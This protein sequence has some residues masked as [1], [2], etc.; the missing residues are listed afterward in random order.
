MF[1]H[2]KK[3]NYIIVTGAHR[4]GTTFTAH[5]IGNDT[6]HT[7]IDEKIIKYRRIRFIPGLFKK[8]DDFVLQAPYALPWVP[9]FTAENVAIVYCKRNKRDIEKSIQNS[10]NLKGQKIST[11]W[12]TPDQANAIWEKIKHLLHNPFE[13]NYKDLKNHPLFVE[14]KDRKNWHYKQVDQTGKWYKVKER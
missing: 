7:V 1:E 5:A 13:I 12:C 9:I 6:K 8:Y 4:S 10:K 14:K 11:P 2:L 3:F